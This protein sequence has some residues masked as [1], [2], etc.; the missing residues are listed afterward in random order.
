[1]KHPPSGPSSAQGGRPPRD[2]FESGDE[3]GA[4]RQQEEAAGRGFRHLGR[5]LL[6]PAALG[7]LALLLLALVADAR[8]L[9]R[10]LRSF[11]ARLLLPVLALSL[12]NYL[13]RFLRWQLYLRSLRVDLAV[14]DS[15]AVFLVG[16]VLSVTPGKLGELGKAWLARELGGGE[17]RR[18][19]AAV[20][21]E[22]ITD[23][24][25]MLLLIAAGAAAIPGVAWLA[26]LCLLTGAALL[27]GLSW[28][29]MVGW[30]LGL[31]QRLPALGSRT[32]LL[33]EVYDLLATLLRPAPLA[34]AL[35]LSFAAWGAEGVGFWIVVRAYDSGATFW[36]GVFNYSAST[37]VGA[38]SMLPGGLLAA[39]GSLTLLLDLQGMATAAAASATLVIRA[40]TLWFAV[41]LGLLALPWV[42]RR[43]RRRAPDQSSGGA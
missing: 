12:V 13:L 34:T 17:A 38:L 19:V 42:L 29:R 10:Q 7:L 30:T 20:L 32:A 9:S 18:A 39:E 2:P 4:A 41:L 24:V 6:V 15:L 35:L 1:V 16:F 36:S 22:R 31:L 28:R 8:E 37:L 25:G 23:V 27:V 40:A 26:A 43:L 14:A 11:D 3:I 21:A 5:R 33:G